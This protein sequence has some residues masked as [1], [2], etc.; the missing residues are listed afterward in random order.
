MI[1]LLSILASISITKASKI[2]EFQSY[3]VNSNESVQELNS[4]T[5]TKEL[6]NEYFPILNNNHSHVTISGMKI[7]DIELKNIN[8]L[9]NEIGKK[10]ENELCGSFYTPKNCLDNQKQVVKNFKNHFNTTKDNNSV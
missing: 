4:N 3:V 1:V 9:F 2:N 10:W 8:T 6:Q 5:N 7:K